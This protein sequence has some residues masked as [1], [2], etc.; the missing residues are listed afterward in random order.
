MTAKRA[1]LSIYAL[2]RL[3]A[4]FADKSK[5]ERHVDGQDASDVYAKA[6]QVCPKRGV[7]RLRHA[8]KCPA[9]FRELGRKVL[10]RAAGRAAEQ[11]RPRRC[12]VQPGDRPNQQRKHPRVVNTA[13]ALDLDFLRDMPNIKS[14]LFGSSL[15]T[16]GTDS[17]A[18]IMAG[19]INPS[20]RTADT[21]SGNPLASPAAQNYGD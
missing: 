5:V 16:Y 20:G 10:H 17:L 6:G 14:M 1:G 2:K 18:G 11:R 3:S 7:R 8:R 9:E 13:S 19:D 21:F 15:G 12:L 4:D